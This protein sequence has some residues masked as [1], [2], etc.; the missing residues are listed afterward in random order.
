MAALAANEETV[1]DMAGRA[2][3][4]EA[5]EAAVA[6]LT[7]PMF[8]GDVALARCCA[9][10]AAVIEEGAI[11]GTSATATAA[12]AVAGVEVEVDDDGVSGDLTEPLGVVG[13]LVVVAA[14]SRSIKRQKNV[15]KAK[16]LEKAKTRTKKDIP[17]SSSGSSRAL[18]WPPETKRTILAGLLGVVAFGA[19]GNR[20]PAASRGAE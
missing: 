4:D 11:A 7:R 16:S 19:K 6:V 2:E 1:A 3:E 9:A 10:A 5:D 12:V 15:R 17:P 20:G 8:G 13:G 18:N 14:S